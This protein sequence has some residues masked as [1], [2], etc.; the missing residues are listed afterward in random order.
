MPK[1]SYVGFWQALKINEIKDV[2][3]IDFQEAVSERKFSLK[4]KAEG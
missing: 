2:K 3:V 1:T 4:T